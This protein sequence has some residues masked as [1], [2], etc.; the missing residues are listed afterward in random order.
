MRVLLDA[1]CW[2]AAAGSSTGGSSRI[3]ELAAHGLLSVV[4]SEG[5][6]IEAE[7]NIARKLGEPALLRFYELLGKYQFER[8]PELRQQEELLWRHLVPEKDCHVLGAAYAAGV[9]VLVSLD[10]RH[11]LADKV[12]RSFPIRVLDTKEFLKILIDKSSPWG[13]ME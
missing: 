4:V 11:I 12:R 5:V 3:L 9:D 10:R 8:A 13:Q 2:V 7:R 1:S 6:L